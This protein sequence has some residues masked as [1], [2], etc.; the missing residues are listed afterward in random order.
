MHL[1]TNMLIGASEVGSPIR[2]QVEAWLRAGEPLQASAMAWAEYLCGP[3]APGEEAAC[4]S[5][6]DQICQMDAATATLGSRLYNFT[7]RRS[8]S[9]ADCLI[10]ATAILAGQ[11]LA[12]A[13]LSH[14]QP[15]T[16]YGLTIFSPGNVP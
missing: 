2:R 12:S 5:L 10:A 16:A 3:L 6:L 9:L 7:G 8:R 4:F 11:P 1:D 13:N 15:F 14:F